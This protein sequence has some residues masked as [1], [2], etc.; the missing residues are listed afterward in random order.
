MIWSGRVE[1]G[2]GNAS[3]LQPFPDGWYQGSLN[4]R[5]D[6]SLTGRIIDGR[7]TSWKQ[8]R[9]MPVIVPAQMQ[10]DDGPL[11]VIIG[12][13]PTTDLT[14]VVAT[15]RLRDRFSLSNGNLVTLSIDDRFVVEGETD[16]TP[17]SHTA[18]RKP[19]AKK[20]TQKTV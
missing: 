7:P 9:W 11:N 16:D 2:K 1:D 13:D 10:T 4:L 8:V 3:R 12:I 15:I 20:S 6:Y 17:R 5:G 14:E 19:R 18:R